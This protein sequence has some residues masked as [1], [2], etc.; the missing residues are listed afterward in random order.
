[1]VLQANGEKISIPE[2]EVETH[3]RSKVS[4]MPEGLLNPLT[5]EEIAD[6]F[7]FLTTPARAELTRRPMR[8]R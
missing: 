1:M 8:T 2:D 4:A 7:A 5:L 3:Q 6:L